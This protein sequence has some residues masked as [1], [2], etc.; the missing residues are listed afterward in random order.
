MNAVPSRVT[1]DSPPAIF[2]GN[3]KTNKKN[4]KML[5]DLP[6]KLPC[7]IVGLANGW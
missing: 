3:L 2:V 1:L 6:H 4:V 7:N 5:S